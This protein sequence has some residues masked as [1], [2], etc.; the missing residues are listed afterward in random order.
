M[1]AL[2]RERVVASDQ[3]DHPLR[4]DIVQ[5]LLQ[6]ADQW[7]QDR[8]NARNS[9]YLLDVFREFLRSNG[10][11]LGAAVDSIGKRTQP[12]HRSRHAADLS[13]RDSCQNCCKLS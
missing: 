9:F 11:R 4:V 1:Q 3:V 13:S 10:H 2:R 6:V 8:R 5:R 7:L 12:L